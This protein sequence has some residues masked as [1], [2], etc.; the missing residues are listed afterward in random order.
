VRPETQRQGHGAALLRAAVERLRENGVDSVLL[1]SSERAPAAVGLYRRFGFDRL[2]V[3]ERVD[4]LSG[5]WVLPLR[6]LP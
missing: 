6:G 5:P 3:R 4:T 1:R 2:P